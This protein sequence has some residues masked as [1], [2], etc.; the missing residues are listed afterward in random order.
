MDGN[1]VRIV[2]IEIAG[3]IAR[4]LDGRGLEAHFGHLLVPVVQLVARLREATRSGHHEFWPDDVSLLDERAID[5]TR[6]H[7]SRQITDLYLLALAVRHEGTFVT[8]D[9]AVARNAV[10]GAEGRHLTVL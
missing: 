7:G 5:S 9:S 6:I 2:H 10:H 1:A 3:A 8:F 4:R